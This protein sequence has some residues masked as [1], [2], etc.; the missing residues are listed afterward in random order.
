M[1]PEFFLDSAFAIALSIET[2][3]FHAKAVQLS[4]NLDN[5]I[6]VTT[7]TSRISRLAEGIKNRLDAT[8]GGRSGGGKAREFVD[9]PASCLT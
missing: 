4:E 1:K 7:S 5:V 8:E 9:L 3:S 6:L 2:D